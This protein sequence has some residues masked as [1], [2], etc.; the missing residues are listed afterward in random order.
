MI[1]FTRVIPKTNQTNFCSYG[2]N[3]MKGEQNM[4]NEI[5]KSRKWFKMFAIAMAIVLT[6][7]SAVPASAA[8]LAGEQSIAVA[9]ATI[10]SDGEFGVKASWGEVVLTYN[11]RNY[12]YATMKTYAGTAYY[13]YAQISGKD[14]LGSIPSESNS[15]YNDS[16]TT[17]AKI[18]SRS[19]SSSVTWTAYG[20]IRDTSA[21]TTQ[22]ATTSK[23]V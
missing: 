13:L 16:S 2:R 11:E 7:A 4:R 20:K 10:T 22:E 9:A 19:T 6:A 8:A 21:S 3:K 15:I 12:A 23:T 5:L 17:T 18:L 14:S 1:D